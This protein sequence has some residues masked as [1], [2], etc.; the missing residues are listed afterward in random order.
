[1]LDAN[2]HTQMLSLSTAM[3]ADARVRLGL[4]EN[5]MDPGIR[6]VVPFSRM[7][8]NAVTVELETVAD[9][10]QADLSP[11]LAAY[12]DP[13]VPFPLMVIQIHADC[14]H[15]GIFGEGAAT[16]ARKSAYEGVLVEGGV[17]DTHELRAMEFPAFSRTICCGYIVGKV[18]VKTVGE[19]VRVGG[20]A[21]AHG[22]AILA[23][24]DGVMVTGQ[25]HL[26]AVIDKALAI[27]EWEGVVMG[28]M[29][30]GSSSQ[31]A[32]QLAGPMP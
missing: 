22:D 28:N 11:I 20:R 25:E 17:R 1:M 23:D 15:R 6:P 24:N 2:T 9:V 4:G 3:L 21:I 7:C 30:A 29:A 12:A 19:P 13:G 5:H 10:S 32:L 14:H 31:E 27:Q 8:G 26:A 16:F 18:R